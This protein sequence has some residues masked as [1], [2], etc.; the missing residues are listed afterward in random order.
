[1]AEVL[2]VLGMLSVFHDG[3]CRVCDHIISGVADAVESVHWHLP[4]K[5]RT[6][7]MEAM[8]DL[9]LSSGDR[10]Q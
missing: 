8:R 10:Q 6:P 2:S 9:R 7:F 3:A 1:L 5:H 4:F